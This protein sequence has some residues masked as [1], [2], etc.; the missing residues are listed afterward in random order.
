MSNEKEFGVVNEGDAAKLIPVELKDHSKDPVIT[1]L[2]KEMEKQ[3]GVPTELVAPVIEKKKR[4]RPKKIVEQPMRQFRCS[5]C[6]EVFSEKSIMKIGTNDG[7]YAAFCP[8]CQRSLGFVDEIMQ[9]K[10]QDLIKNNPT[11]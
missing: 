4:G 6:R 2:V 8:M 7:R 1:E 9:Q 5:T 11:E 10:V 3:T